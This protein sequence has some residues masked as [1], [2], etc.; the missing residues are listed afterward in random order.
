MIVSLTSAFP[1]LSLEKRL[2]TWRYPNV[3]SSMMT[4]I[5]PRLMMFAS[6]N[7]DSLKEIVALPS[8]NAPLRYSMVEFSIM[9]CGSPEAPSVPRWLFST[10]T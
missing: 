3:Q 1:G 9:I 5:S 7:L 8:R 4:F 6:S 10:L 2:L